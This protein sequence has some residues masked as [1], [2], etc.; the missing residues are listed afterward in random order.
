MK[1]NSFYLKLGVDCDHVCLAKDEVRAL[2]KKRMVHFNLKSLKYMQSNC[3]VTDLPKINIYDEKCETCHLGKPHRLPFSHNDVMRANL[4]LELAHSNLCGPMKTPS[5]N[6]ST[7]FVL[8]IDDLGVGLKVSIIEYGGEYV[9]K[10]FNDLCKE[11]GIH[12]QLTITHTS[13]QNGVFERRNGTILNMSIF[14]LIDKQ[15]PMPFWV[16]VIATSMY[17]LN[18]LATKAVNRKTPLEAWF[19]FKPFVEHLK[20]DN[21][22]N[23]E[24]KKIMVMKD[25]TFDEETVTN[26]DVENDEIGNDSSTE[27]TTDDEVIKAKT[28]ANVY[29]SCNLIFVVPTSFSEASRWVYKNKFNPNGTVFKNKARY[30]VKGH[31]RIGGVDYGDT[32]SLVARLDTIRLLIAITGALSVQAQESSLWPEI[33]SIYVDDLLVKGSNVEFVSTFKLSMQEKFK[34]YNLVLMSYILS[35]EINQNELLKNDGEKLEDYST[36]RSLVGNVHLGFAKRVLRYVKSTMCE[37]LNYLET[38]SVLLNGYS[39]SDWARSL[40]GMKSTFG[41]VFNLGSS[42]ICWS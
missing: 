2:W 30:V 19:G 24:T 39:D 23:L 42:G 29:Q 7:Y 40:D 16:E 32:F 38:G 5:L 35:M 22:F 25:V 12:H 1:N 26:D 36:F 41:Y 4:K 18:K 11:V 28:L 27:N 20:G 6:R 15:L 17:M 13:Q 9:S 14:M 3:F 10:E 31:T 8:F 34:M 33:V 21:V 37:E